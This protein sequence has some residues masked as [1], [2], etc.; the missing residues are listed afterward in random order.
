MVGW[1]I[2]VRRAGER[3]GH[4]GRTTSQADERLAIWQA[5]PG[6]CGWLDRLVEVG[7]ARLLGGNGFPTR[8]SG[9]AGDLAQVILDGPPQAQS[10][11]AIGEDSLATA[12]WLGETWIERDGLAACARDEWLMI[13]AWDES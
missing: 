4:A 6:G 11:W 12:E 1:L 7:Q 3:G 2:I 8:Y 13:E 10:P 5:G 9:Q